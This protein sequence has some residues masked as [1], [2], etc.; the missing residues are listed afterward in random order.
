MQLHGAALRPGLQGGAAASQYRAAYGLRVPEQAVDTDQRHPVLGCV[1]KVGA[2]YWVGSG[3][4]VSFVEVGFF[5]FVVH[6]VRLLTDLT[7]P[8]PI[9]GMEHS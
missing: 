6:Y 7:N 4:C 3:G 1:V 2:V 9:L 5:F 8:Y